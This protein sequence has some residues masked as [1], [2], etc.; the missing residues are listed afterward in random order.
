MQ[1]SYRVIKSTVID[2]KNIITT[3]VI[4]ILKP[5]EK[6]EVVETTVENP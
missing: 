5:P 2:G 1:S 3:P 6:T 4:E